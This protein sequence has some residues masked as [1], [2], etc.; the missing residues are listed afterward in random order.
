MS[1]ITEVVPGIGSPPLTTDPTT[2]D[3]RADLLYGTNLPAAIASMNVAFGQVNVVTAEIAANAAAVAASAP[4]AIAAANFKGAWST[5]TGAL[6]I[7]A[8]V[9]HSSEVWMLT[10]SVAD[11]TTE[12]PGVSAKWLQVSPEGAGDHSLVL[13]SGNGHGSTNTMI[14]RLV[15]MQSSSGTAI[16]YVD[17]AT[18]GATITINETGMYSIYYLDRASTYMFI[19]VS[20]NSSQLTTS[21]VSINAVDRL[22]LNGAGADPLLVSGTV[23][24]TAGDVIRLHTNGAPSF[25]DV[26]NTV[27]RIRKVGT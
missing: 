24:L 27:F 2:F 21:V 6:A 4:A 1:T 26:S 16:T 14:R 15:I 12:V 18:L 8:S 17:S 11:V 13:T 3:P 7:P 20:V 5:L 22:L 10:E 19:G 25:T 9:S 23:F